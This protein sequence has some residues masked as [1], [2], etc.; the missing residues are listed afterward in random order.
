MYGASIPILMKAE[1]AANAGIEK[2][3]EFISELGLPSTLRE[4]GATEEMLPL[5]AKSTV[6]GGGYRQMNAD[7][8]LTV[9][10]ECY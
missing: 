4:L 8:I 3:G 2:L 5:I 7:D 6:T 1:D 10:K 9:L